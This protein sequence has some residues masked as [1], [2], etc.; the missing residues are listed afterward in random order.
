MMEAVKAEKLRKRKMILAGGRGFLGSLLAKFFTEQG[1]QVVIFSRNRAKVSAGR[2]VYWD[3]ETLGDW[4]AELEGA[5][6]LINL[7]G[8][9]VNCRYTEKNQKI[10]T[11]SRLLPTRVLA[12]AVAKCSSPPKIWMNASTATIYQHT[13]GPAQTESKGTFSN[14]PDAKDKFS[15]ELASGWEQEFKQAHCPETR[16]I[17]LRAAIVFGNSPGTIYTVLKRLVRLGLGGKMGSGKQYVS[18][19]HAEDF[20]RAIDFLIENR[21]LSGPVNLASPNP[22]TNSEM[23]RVLRKV[24]GV[25]FG[26]PATQM[27]LEIGAFFLRT[28]TELVIKSRRVVS[29]K[30]DQAGFTFEHPLF[31]AAMFDLNQTEGDRSE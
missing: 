7:S 6:V 23:M 28:E 11:D 10:L 5:D 13:F 1:Y 24:W 15:V 8:Q 14:N 27:M 30:L 29:E 2:I 16:K 3:G 4:K 22:I 18:W 20:C 17:L 21:K 26:L 31:E 9:T 25:T 12:Q 19:I